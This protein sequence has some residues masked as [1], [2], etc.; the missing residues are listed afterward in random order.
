MEW[1][2]HSLCLDNSHF[3]FILN[4]Y[5]ERPHYSFSEHPDFFPLNVCDVVYLLF[6]IHCFRLPDTSAPQHQRSAGP[7]KGSG[8]AKT[9]PS[10]L[11]RTLQVSKAPRATGSQR[12]VTQPAGGRG[13]PVSVWVCGS[14]QWVPGGT[15]AP[16]RWLP[17]TL[18][19]GL[20][21]PDRAMA[22]EGS[23]P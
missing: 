4:A 20:G 11:Q 12:S 7:P 1:S 18:I 17:R 23:E 9:S 8:Q 14:S 21:L 16:G 13:A 10:V 6:S 22:T 2:P 3:S 19:G 15:C 5:S